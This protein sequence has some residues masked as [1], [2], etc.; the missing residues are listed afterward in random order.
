MS[1]KSTHT[2]KKNTNMSNETDIFLKNEHFF[3][4]R[5]TMRRMHT[6][7]KENTHLSKETYIYMIYVKRNLQYW[8]KETCNVY[9]KRPVMYVKRDLQWRMYSPELKTHECQKIIREKIHICTYM[10]RDLYLYEKRRIYVWKEIYI[11][12]K[13]NMYV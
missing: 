10:K 8:W 4:K 6:P 9:A 3:G 12:V 5:S 11:Y 2:S 13:R 7:E 1:K